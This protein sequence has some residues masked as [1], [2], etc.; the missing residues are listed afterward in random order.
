MLEKQA[1]KKNPKPKNREQTSPNNKTQFRGLTRPKGKTQ[2]L[3]L[4][5][6]TRSVASGTDRAVLE[7][8]SG[9]N[10]DGEA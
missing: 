6:E 10:R 7:A 9:V 1:K 3:R 2:G 4:V 5:V 8:G